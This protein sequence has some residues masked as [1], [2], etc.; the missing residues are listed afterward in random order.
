MCVAIRPASAN[1]MNVAQRFFEAE[2]SLTI[3]SYR[4]FSKA[5]APRKLQIN[6]H[7]E[8]RE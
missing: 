1:M 4:A 7:C 6:S 2:S 3:R 8:V 5:V